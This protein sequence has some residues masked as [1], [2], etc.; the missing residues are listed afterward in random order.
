MFFGS[1][2]QRSFIV[3]VSFLTKSLFFPFELMKG[4]FLSVKEYLAFKN[5]IGCTTN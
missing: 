2:R 5:I 1:D 4:F 3:S